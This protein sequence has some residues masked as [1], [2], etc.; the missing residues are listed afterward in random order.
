VN[1]RLASPFSTSLLRALPAAGLALAS[2]G[3]AAAWV[4]IG[5]SES[6]AYYLDADSVRSE[7]THRRIWRLFDYKEQPRE[8]VKSGKAL[9]DIDCQAGTYR[10]LKT[11]YYSEAM[12]KG[13]SVGGRGEHR[14]E[15]IAPGT[16]I[17]QLA[18]LVCQPAARKQAQ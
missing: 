8:G 1:L 12:G 16:M 2:A 11:M 9:I 5:E 13:V 18:N 4:P 3:V 10:Y 7:G 15:Y 14:K 17:G 6:T